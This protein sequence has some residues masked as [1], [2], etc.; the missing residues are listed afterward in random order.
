MNTLFL[1]ETD[2]PQIKDILISIAVIKLDSLR[3]FSQHRSPT[4]HFGGGHPVALWPPNSNTAE[5]FVRC[6]YPPSFIILC[7]LVR[8]LSCWQANTHIHTQTSKQTNRRREKH[9]T[10]FA[11]L[12]CLAITCVCYCIWLWCT[13]QL[14]RAARAIVWHAISLR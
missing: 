12:R 2:S 9:P 5:M 3:W 7:L 11:T 8:K 1:Q 4:A 6:T 10:L 14:V 13:L